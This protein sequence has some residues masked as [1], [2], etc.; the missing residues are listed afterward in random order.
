[1]DIPALDGE[2]GNIKLNFE[3]GVVKQSKTE[4]V[5]VG[6]HAICAHLPIVPYGHA[7]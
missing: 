5:M 2:D 4:A 1:L 6:E 7:W 3:N